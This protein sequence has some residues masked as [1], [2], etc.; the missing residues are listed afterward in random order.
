MLGRKTGKQE[1]EGLHQRGV[2]VRGKLE[3]RKFR[4]GPSK[5]SANPLRRKNQPV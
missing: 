1:E 5:K 3:K 4:E 2:A